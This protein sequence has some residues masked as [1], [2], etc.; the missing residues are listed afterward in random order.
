MIEHDKRELLDIVREIAKDEE[1]VDAVTELEELI[2][3]YLEDEFLERESVAEKVHELLD[4]LSKSK[5]IPKSTH[6]KMKML[7][8][9]IAKNRAR[10]KDIVHRFNQVGGDDRQGRVWILAQLAKEKLLSEQ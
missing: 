3:V 5:H 1:I 9:D 2:A 7:V 6:L 10:V 4:R 8:G